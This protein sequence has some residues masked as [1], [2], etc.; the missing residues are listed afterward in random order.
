MGVDNK[1]KQTQ[2]TAKHS[3]KDLLIFSKELK[4]LMGIVR[5]VALN[6]RPKHN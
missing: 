2:K 3:K 4:L 6:H 5:E 1:V